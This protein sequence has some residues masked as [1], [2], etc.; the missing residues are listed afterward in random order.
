MYRCQLCRTV[1]PP[2]TPAQR[3]VVQTR[4]KKYPFRLKVNRVVRKPENGKP[5]V[6]FVDDPGGVGRE[7]ERELVVCPVCAAG[8]NGD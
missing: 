6:T 5:K 3:A 8:R 4:V 2:R 7:V 1:V